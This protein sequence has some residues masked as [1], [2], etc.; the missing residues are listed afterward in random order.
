MPRPGSG[1]HPMNPH[2]EHLSNRDPDG[3]ASSIMA[4]MDRVWRYRQ[5]EINARGLDLLMKFLTPQQKADF[6]EHGSFCVK[7]SHSGKTYVINQNNNY[8]VCDGQSFWCFTP[9]HV[10]LCIPDVMLAQK[11][12]LESDE[13]ATLRVANET[14]AHNTNNPS[15]N[16]NRPDIRCHAAAMANTAL[17]RADHR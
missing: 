11:I 5:A 2:G 15:I 14:S 12:V 1:A 10:G 9:S 17:G 8:N 3:W 13:P 7:G 4:E 6:V 16:I